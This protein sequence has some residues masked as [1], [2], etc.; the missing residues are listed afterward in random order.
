[1]SNEK[2]N[3][4]AMAEALK[5]WGTVCGSKGS[6]DT[7]AVVAFLDAGMTCMDFA[8]AYPKKFLSILKEHEGDHNYYNEFCIRFPKCD[9]TEAEC[10]TLFCR[11]AMFQGYLD[12]EKSDDDC[13]ACWQEKYAGD[14]TETAPE[15]NEDTTDVNDI[16]DIL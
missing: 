1:M 7:C 16:L 3:N 14:V 5:L 15:S 10:A 12:C 2:N 8:K 13:L 4:E 6:C 9:L 11:K